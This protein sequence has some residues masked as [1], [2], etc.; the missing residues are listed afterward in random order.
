MAHS[1]K[2]AQACSAIDQIFVSTD[3]PEI[4]ATAF[5]FGASVIDRPPNL[6][7]DE[8][9]TVTALQHVLAQTGPRRVVLLQPTN[10]LRPQTLLDDALQLFDRQQIQSLFTVSQ[11]HHKLGKIIGE[12]FV[13][14]NYQPGQRSQDLDPLYFENGLLYICEPSV[15]DRGLI[16]APEA[17]PMVIDHPFARVDID[18]Q[19]DFDY[20]EFLYHKYKNDESLP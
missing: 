2:Y 17:H 14:Y 4:K 7:G 3:N 16:I 6:S 19:D 5:G 13:P 12:N 8:E 15:L 1:I 10:P 11:S 9:P 18:I 20:A